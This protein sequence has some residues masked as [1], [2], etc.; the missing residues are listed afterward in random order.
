M[1]PTRLLGHRAK[2]AQKRV[3]FIAGLSKITGPKNKKLQNSVSFLFYIH[4][5]REKQTAYAKFE[6]NGQKRQKMALKPRRVK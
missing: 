6:K 3:F 5:T 1:P 4:I 2:K